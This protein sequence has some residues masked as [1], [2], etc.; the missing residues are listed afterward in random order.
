MIWNTIAALFCSIM[1]FF[2]PCL[3]SSSEEDDDD[4]DDSNEEE[5]DNKSEKDDEES[6][7]Y[8]QSLAK[9]SESVPESKYS[10]DTTES[11]LTENLDKIHISKDSP[12]SSKE[13]T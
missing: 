3:L 4:E 11:D 13:E 6:E 8:H 12:T 2:F 7:D 5:D 9:S 10:C 1:N